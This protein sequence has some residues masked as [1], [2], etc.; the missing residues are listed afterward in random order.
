L[1]QTGVI[2]AGV[3]IYGRESGFRSS[4]TTACSSWPG[5]SRPS[6]C[7]LHAGPERKAW[8]PAT[9]A[10]MT[11]YGVVQSNRNNTTASV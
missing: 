11:K 3:R 4:G 6:T 10:G 9:S 7:C 8:M 2:Q 1:S 5:L